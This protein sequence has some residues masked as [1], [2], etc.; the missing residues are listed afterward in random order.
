MIWRPFELRPEGTPPLDPNSA[1]MQRAWRESIEP[2]SRELGVEM[3]RPSVHPNTRLAHEAQAFA[4]RMGRGAEMAAA[5]FAAYW[6]QGR[7][8]GETEVIC[9]VGL[10]AGVDPVALR[11]CLAERSLM[12]E[13]GEELALAHRYGITAVPSFVVGDRFLLR[14]LVPEEHLRRAIGMCKGEGLINLEE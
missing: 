5:L 6:Q 1:Y 10:S 4:Q 3:R 13:V 12:A 9:D 2:L 7:D 8:I 14:G 11:Q